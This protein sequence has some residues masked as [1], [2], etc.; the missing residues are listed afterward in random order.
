[1]KEAIMTLD[2]MRAPMPFSASGPS[3]ATRWERWKRGLESY[4]LALNVNQSNRKRAILLHVG[5]EELQDI[6]DGLK[7]PGDNYEKTIDALNKH[8]SPT[9]NIIF[10]CHMFQQI[11]QNKEESIDAFASRLRQA[12]KSCEFGE[13]IDRMIAVQIVN[14]CQ[15]AALRKRFLREES[16]TLDSIL[17]IGRAHEAGELRSKQY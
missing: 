13:L 16:L 12:A 11:E 1:D 10:E 5:G 4:L 8:F 9:K 14:R 15:S 6:V 3:V 17:Q 2:S 7:D